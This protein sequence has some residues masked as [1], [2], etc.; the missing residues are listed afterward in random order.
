MSATKER[1]LICGNRGF[2]GGALERDLPAEGFAVA[3]AD[4]GEVEQAIDAF[5]PTALVWAAGSRGADAELMQRQHVEA[6]LAALT[7]SRV[8]QMV[9]ISTGELYGPQAVPFCETTAPSP[10]SAYARAKLR[11][12]EELA[13]LADR[14]GVSL[15]RIRLPLAYGPTQRGP[16]FLPS[17]LESLL[18]RRPFP[19]TAG[20]Q[21]RDYLYIDDLVSAI[22]EVLRQERR[23]VLNVGSDE[24]TRLIDLARLAADLVGDGAEE[25]L[26]VGAV[27]YRAAE[28]MRYVLDASLAREELGFEPKISLEAGVECCVRQRRE[29]SE[30]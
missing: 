25:L 16:M 9:Y 13:A 19:M 24:E 2:I 11:G 29:Q 30:G 18:S 20:E 22:A 5:A 3:G 17:L 7:R 6:P 15:C 21:T 8:E 10:Q 28:Q 4:Q 12:E 26:Q 14:R 1:V 23:G 27:P